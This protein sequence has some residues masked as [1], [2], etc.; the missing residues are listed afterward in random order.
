MK[1]FDKIFAVVIL[2][3]AVIVTAANLILINRTG[4]E[5]GRPYRVEINRIALEIEENGLDEVD[6]SKCKYVTG[7]EKYTGDDPEFY[8]SGSDYAMRE[9]GGE[10]YRFDYSYSSKSNNSGIIYIVNAIL[11]MMALVIIGVMLFIRVAVISPFVKMIDVPFEL[12]KGNLTVPIKESRNRFFGRF[13]WGVD[14]LRETLEQQKQRE[15]ELQREKKTLLLSLSHDIKTPLSAIKLYSKALSKGIYADRRKQLEIIENI[16]V[17]ADEIEGFVSEIV[18]ASNEDFLCLE[19]CVGEFYLSQAINKISEYYSE[20]LALIGTDF[21]VS[22]Y[23]DC[24]VK[25]DK[26]R[27]IEVLQNII[28]NAV[29]YGDGRSVSVEL[30]EEEE[31]RLI[32]V[33][34]SGCT[35]PET[36][37]PHIFDSFW[38][39]SNAGE[40]AGS[41][42][43][44]YICRQLMRRMD[45]EIFAEISGGNMCVTAIVRLAQ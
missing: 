18:K 14:L 7:I 31:S 29:K 21:S 12:S 1:S 13:L 42:L 27:L 37:L 30:S 22:G 6:V 24:I 3:L 43:G 4:A 9:A 32:C 45:G 15:L 5:N 28:E 36:E 39:G 44:L 20:K 25:G 41:G 16:N 8:S 34:N 35:L 19:V 11:I 40:N 23:C 38:R 26:D 10:L 33:K 2:M 17:K